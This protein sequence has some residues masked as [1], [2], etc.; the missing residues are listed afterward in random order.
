LALTPAQYNAGMAGP[1]LQTARGDLVRAGD[2]LKAAAQDGRA[3][4]AEL[5]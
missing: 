4:I 3:V 2:D 5:N 1:V